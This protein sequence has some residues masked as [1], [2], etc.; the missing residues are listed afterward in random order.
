[1]KEYICKNDFKEFFFS[2]ESGTEEIIEDL[3]MKHNLDYLHDVNE[4]DVKEF[5]K[6]LIIGMRNVLDTEETVTKADI[7]REIMEDVGCNMIEDCWHCPFAK[8]GYCLVEEKL[9]EMENE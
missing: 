5:A 1:M 3:M 8:E 4:E 7:F 2:L 9:A 6:D